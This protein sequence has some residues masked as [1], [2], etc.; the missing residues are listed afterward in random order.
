MK[1]AINQCLFTYL[2][3]GRDGYGTPFE[4]VEKYVNGEITWL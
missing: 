3:S 2:S 1:M 4:A